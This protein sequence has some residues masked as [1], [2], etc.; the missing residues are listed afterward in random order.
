MTLQ[1]GIEMCVFPNV[2]TQKS[3]F[4]GHLLTT[5]ETAQATLLRSIGA[6][7]LPLD[8]SI[9]VAWHLQTAPSLYVFSA[10]APTTN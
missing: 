3:A 10:P 9:L 4:Q 1:K 8:L 5:A 7:F 2:I 6:L